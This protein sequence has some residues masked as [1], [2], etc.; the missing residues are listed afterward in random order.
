MKMMAV[1]SLI[2][3]TVPVTAIAECLL[4]IVWLLLHNFMFIVLWMLKSLFSYIQTKQTLKQTKSLFQIEF[5]RIWWWNRLVPPVQHF[6][7][8]NFFLFLI[9]AN[10]II[11][12]EFNI[13]IW[14][15]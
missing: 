7:S 13:A 3:I 10:Y 9:I 5:L 14:H 11:F 8:N 2:S 1:V 15:Y 6:W 4:I 12:F